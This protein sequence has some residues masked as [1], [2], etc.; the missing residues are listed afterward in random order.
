MGNFK[1]D[2]SGSFGVLTGIL[3]TSIYLVR[4]YYYLVVERAATK[5]IHTDSIRTSYGI[6]ETIYMIVNDIRYFVE[7]GLVYSIDNCVTRS[8][9]I[10]RFYAV[11]CSFKPVEIAF[12][13]SV[14]DMAG[15]EIVTLSVSVISINHIRPFNP[16]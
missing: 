15:Q 12:G 4:T 11:V 2:I 6:V 10:C 13:R 1:Y 7:H 9:R 16:V 3:E 8:T 5:I 14:C